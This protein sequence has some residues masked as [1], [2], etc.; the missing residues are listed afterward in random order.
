[1]EKQLVMKNLVTLILLFTCLTGYSQVLP[2]SVV[3]RVGE[4]DILLSEFLY[5]AQ[6]NGEADF[7]NEQSLK[8]YI[9]LF[10]NFK[11]KVAEAEHYGLD[12]TR[13]FVDE[14][15]TYRGQLTR[16]Y[17]SDKD[18]E[19]A[20]AK[21]IYDRGNEILEI[22][23][24][25]YRLPMK[26]LAK[27]TLVV[28][29][30][31]MKTYQRVLKGQDLDKLGKKLAEKESDKIAYE[32]IRC[33][34]PM[35]RSKALENVVYMMNPG[36]ISKPI[37]TPDGYYIVKMHSRKPN[38]GSIQV[39]HI[40]IA[41]SE[42]ATKKDKAEALKQANELLIQ[43]ESGSDFAELA[44]EYSA[45]IATGQNGGVLPYSVPGSLFQQFED[46]AYSLSSVGEISKIVE[47][48]HGYH[49]LKLIGKKPR[50]SF[51]E[52]KESLI[53][54]MSKGEYNFDIYKVADERLKK[55]LGYVFHP[56]AYAELE[57]LSHDYFPSDEAYFEKAQY[58]EKPLLHLNETPFDQKEFAYYMQRN[59]FSVKTYAGDF[60]KE[61]YD[62]FVRDLVTITERNSLETKYPE[63][64]H[65]IQEYRD[66]ILLFEISNQMIWSQPVAEQ[67]SLEAEWIKRLNEK[68]PVV[69]NWDIVKKLGK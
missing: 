14:F 13:A 50:R 3:M 24:I 61:V 69:I 38:P 18:A 54:G 6:K 20:A 64:L 39:A 1:M 63:Y 15:A 51:G 7:S 33:L 43:I 17:L 12:K 65:L 19:E 55:G 42:K 56:E 26:S 30:E 49:I 41:V 57:E 58:M 44:K 23:A 46:A 52:E 35:K 45:D 29:N 48:P 27:D 53:A 2:D 22:S 21:V 31:A 47:T 40:L 16:S 8:D 11:L 34:Y 62:L 4:K 32:Y 28:Y 37:R 5:I 68:Y 60:M 25:V 36:D 66:G 67:A 10:K 59:P 9:E